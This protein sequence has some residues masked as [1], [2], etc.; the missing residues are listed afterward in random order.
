MTS[1]VITPPDERVLHL[2]IKGVTGLICHNFSQKARLEMAGIQAQKAKKPRGPRDPDAEYEASFYHLPDGSHGFPCS[3][4]KKSAIRAAKMVDGISMT[5]CRQMFFVLPDGRDEG[6]ID[7]VKIN[8][9]AEMRTD[10]I[11]VKNG[12]ADLRYRPEIT[13]WTATLRITYDAGL[14][15]PEQIASLFYRAGYSV[16]VG[17]WRPERDGDFGRYTISETISLPADAIGSPIVDVQQ[18]EAA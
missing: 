16:G 15:S 13:N 11:R 14:I 1:V 4:F 7:C 3:G 12:A 5:D 18:Q 6:G 2:D 17:D 9:A 8:G 10:V